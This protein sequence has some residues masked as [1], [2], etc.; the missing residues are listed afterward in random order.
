MIG[1]KGICTGPPV[2]DQRMHVPLDE[3]LHTPAC[4]EIIRQVHE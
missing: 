1:L 2:A 3:H 4:N